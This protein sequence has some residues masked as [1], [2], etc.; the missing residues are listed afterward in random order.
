MSTEPK[1]HSPFPWVKS[2]LCHTAVA[3]KSRTTEWI[4]GSGLITDHPLPIVECLVGNGITE[5]ESKA[6][7]NFI[8]LAVN[9]HDEL[10]AALEDMVLAFNGEEVTDLHAA[11]QKADSV[12][13]K[14]KE[15]R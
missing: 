15:G 14:V 6:N 9:H 3:T 5:D 8:L 12:L 2:T 13:A 7:L 10:V 4:H 11:L 1:A